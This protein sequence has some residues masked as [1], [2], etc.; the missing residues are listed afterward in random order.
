MLPESG[1]LEHLGKEAQP[2]AELVV[3][4]PGPEAGLLLRGEGIRLG[5]DGV[6]GLG[7]L[8]GGDV[9]GSPPTQTLWFVAAVFMTFPFLMIVLSLFLAQKANRWANMVMAVIFFS[10]N[11]YATLGYESAYDT[12]LGVVGLV[13]NVIVFWLALKWKPSAA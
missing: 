6:E 3:E 1:A 10:V 11:L 4:Q 8:P 9:F 2:G 13:F 12:Y 7:D 5:A